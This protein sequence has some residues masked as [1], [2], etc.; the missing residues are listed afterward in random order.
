MPLGKKV[1]IVILIIV[2]AAALLLTFLRIPGETAG[3]TLLA[4]IITAGFIFY[5]YRLYARR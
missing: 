3:F 1:L 2:I 4:F 5:L